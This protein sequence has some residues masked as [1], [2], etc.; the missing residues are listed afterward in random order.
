[1]GKKNVTHF[2]SLKC[3]SL[4]IIPLIFGCYLS[5]YH[6]I[7]YIINARKQEAGGKIKASSNIWAY[8]FHNLGSKISNWKIKW[9][10]LLIMNEL[11]EWERD[12]VCES[13]K[14]KEK[15]IKPG[16]GDNDWNGK[17][18]YRRE[19][20]NV[21]SL[22]MTLHEPYHQTDI[23]YQAARTHTIKKE[24]SDIFSTLYLR[25]WH[26]PNLINPSNLLWN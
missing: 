2:V 25:L 21:E 23:R 20:K 14:E 3:R 6:T 13:E 18:I 26:S 19:K 10:P 22:A 17:K 8:V 7:F 1:M 12:R 5:M 4:E 15:L 24:L 16:N 9:I 11:W